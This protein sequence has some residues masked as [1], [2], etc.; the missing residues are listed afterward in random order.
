[1]CYL[2]WL[3][4][5]VLALCQCRQGLAASQSKLGMCLQAPVGPPQRQTGAREL[6]PAQRSDSP[7]TPEAPP[8]SFFASRQAPPVS[9]LTPQVR[10]AGRQEL[11][12]RP[13]QSSF[14]GRS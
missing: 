10:P 2:L 4:D 11:P 14:S 3:I 6:Q 5:S 1:M 9:Y 8:S 13:K 7:P 12:C